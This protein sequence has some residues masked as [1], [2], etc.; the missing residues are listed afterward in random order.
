MPGD[1]YRW[2]EPRRVDSPTILTHLDW[3]TTPQITEILEGQCD[4]C[5]MGRLTRGES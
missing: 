1:T 2:T 4:F 5:Y 3:F